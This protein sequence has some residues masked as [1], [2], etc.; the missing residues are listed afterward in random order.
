MKLT[1]VD[2]ETLLACD[3]WKAG[4]EVVSIRGLEDTN[5]NR[6]NVMR[7]LSEL[8]KRGLL[9]FGAVNSTFRTTEAGRA[10]LREEE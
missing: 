7:R 3:D 10:L 8:T 5:S 4:W 9:K 2:R 1:K 6:R